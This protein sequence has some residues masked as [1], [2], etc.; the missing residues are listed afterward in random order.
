MR[1]KTIIGIC[2][3]FLAIP[4][5]INL[6]SLIPAPYKCWEA[7]SM[8]TSFW[9][10]YISGFASLAMLYVAWKTLINAREVNRPFIIVDLIDKKGVLFLRCRNIGNSTAYGI[11][12]NIS[13]TFIDTI[14]IQQ[15][16]DAFYDV[17]KQGEFML[18]SNGKKLFDLLMIPCSYNDKMYRF[19]W[20]KEAYYPFK[21][22]RILKSIWVENEK[23]FTQ[24]SF[25]CTVKYN[26]YSEKFI[27]DYNNRDEDIEPA[28]YLSDYLMSISLNLNSIKEEIKGI[29]EKINDTKQDK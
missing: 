9:G 10:Q 13:Q 12:I 22:E 28:K 18:E 2:C 8:W 17:N 20:E 6:L 4:L 16:K 15:V 27:L 19:Q 29:K 14:K 5:L 1:I 7:P 25:E 21:G 3:L 24:N 26:E 11:K 23:I